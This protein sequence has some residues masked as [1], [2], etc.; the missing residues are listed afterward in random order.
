MDYLG[1][2]SGSF[3]KIIVSS[4]LLFCQDLMMGLLRNID[5]I[6]S[7]KS[8]SLLVGL[9]GIA[10]VAVYG[11]KL[12]RSTK[13][14]LRCKDVGRQLSSLAEIILYGLIHQKVICTSIEK[15]RIVSSSDK[16]KNAF[17]YLD[18]GS[19][20]E[21][22]QFIQTLHELVSQI[23]N[24][25]Y[26][27]KH[28]RSLLFLKKDMYYPIPE[29]FAKNKKNADFFKKLWDKMI[30]KSELVFTRTIEGR[31]ILLKLRFQALLNRN[32]RIE[33]LHKWTR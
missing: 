20:Y 16:N 3:A 4:I 11:G 32:G 9:F 30:G 1:K 27:L 10:G 31:E 13:Q 14:Y 8:F 28:K 25:R 6:K 18:G 29:I 17:C 19:Q 24:P 33:H 12:Y 26:L 7:V 15:L 2:M 5:E 21:N 23:D 22:A